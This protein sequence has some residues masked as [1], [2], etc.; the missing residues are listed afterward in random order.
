MFKKYKGRVAAVIMEPVIGQ[1][2]SDFIGKRFKANQVE[3]CKNCNQ[4]KALK[5]EKNSKENNR[6]SYLMNVYQD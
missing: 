6:Y 4:V 5:F 2:C 1:R 3:N